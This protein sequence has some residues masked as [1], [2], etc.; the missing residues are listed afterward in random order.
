MS[1]EVMPQNTP[2]D[3][4][5]TQPAPP[6]KPRK[7]RRPLLL[8]ETANHTKGKFDIIKKRLLPSTDKENSG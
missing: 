6:P 7:K 5:S 8:R 4:K 1:D 3:G 2:E